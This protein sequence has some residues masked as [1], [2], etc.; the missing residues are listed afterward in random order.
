MVGII[1]YGLGN[2][3]AFVNIYKQL[4]IPITV[5][6][7]HQQLSTITKLIL[8]GVG[9]FDYAMQQFSNSGMR[10]PVSK[11][12][13]EDKVPVIGICVGMQMLANGSDE[14]KE[15]G[16]GWINGYV[17]KFDPATISNKTHLPHMGWNDVYPTGQGGLFSGMEKD[18]RFYFLHSYYFSCNEPQDTIAEAEYGIKYACAVN[19]SNI[20]GVQFHPEKSHHFGIRLLENFARI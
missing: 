11:M 9:H 18:A 20:Y 17:H 6:N 12:V 15:K 16:L 2:I 7:S 5:V 19:H 1:D 10:E 8:P 4:N 14:G 13:L 3:N